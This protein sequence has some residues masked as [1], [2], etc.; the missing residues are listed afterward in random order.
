V[1]EGSCFLLPL[2]M[3]VVDDECWMEEGGR[4]E[5]NLLLFLGKMGSKTITMTFLWHCFLTMKSSFTR[6]RH[7]NPSIHALLWPIE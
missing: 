7:V 4:W 1:G 5:I 2:M 6:S 3:Y